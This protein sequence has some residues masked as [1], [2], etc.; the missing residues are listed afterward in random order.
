MA[1]PNAYRYTVVVEGF[2]NVVVLSHV[3]LFRTT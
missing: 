3:G 2:F 1:D